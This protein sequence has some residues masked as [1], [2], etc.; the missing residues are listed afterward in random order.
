MPNFSNSCFKAYVGRGRCMCISSTAGSANSVWRS[1][2]RSGSRLPPAQVL[3]IVRLTRAQLLKGHVE[4]ILRHRFLEALL[5]Q[6]ET[7]SVAGW[8][9]LYYSRVQMLN[10]GLSNTSTITFA[11]SSVG[12]TELQTSFKNPNLPCSHAKRSCRTHSV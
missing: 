1:W 11:F 6:R 9:M 7:P 10:C 5:G 3:M 8:I 12:R 4:G 2:W